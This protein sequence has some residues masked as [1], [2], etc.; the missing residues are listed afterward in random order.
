LALGAATEPTFALGEFLAANEPKQ[1]MALRAA[2]M[3]VSA[4]AFLRYLA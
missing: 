2:E 3:A 4:G 1:P